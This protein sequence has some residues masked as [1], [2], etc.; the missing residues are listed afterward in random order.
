MYH[1]LTIESAKL[2]QFTAQL[3]FK[4]ARYP[5]LQYSLSSWDEGLFLDLV[6]GSVSILSDDCPDLL[7]LDST[8]NHFD[9]TDLHAFISRIP[10]NVRNA[11]RPFR[12]KQLQLLHMIQK[13]PRIM[14]LM[15]SIPLL[16]W[17]VADRINNRDFT[18]HQAVKLASK[19]RNLILQNISGKGNDAQIKFIKKTIGKNLDAEE[20]NLLWWAVGNNNVIKKLTHVSM[21]NLNV[22][23]AVKERPAVLDTPAFFLL[24]DEIKG[25]EGSLGKARVISILLLSCEQFRGALGDSDFNELFRN[26]A[27]LRQLHNRHNFLHQRYNK[28]LMKQQA[29]INREKEACARLKQKILTIEASKSRIPQQSI[30]KKAAQPRKVRKPTSSVWNGCFPLPPLPGIPGVIEPITTSE[31]LKLEGATLRNCVGKVKYIKRINSKR[32]YIY[33]VYSPERCTLELKKIWKSGRTY[34]LRNELR[35]YDNKIPGKATKIF[36]DSWLGKAIKDQNGSS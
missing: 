10:S 9:Q 30:T 2:N 22:L 36:V 15:E 8:N 5:L 20:S 21:V 19:K 11:V 32:F 27:D 28:T 17:M 33:K 31:E 3:V 1:R 4:P 12:W 25:P 29:L 35:S 16:V 13:E 6:P 14:E 23:K 26:C 7:L 24:A 18:L 34:L